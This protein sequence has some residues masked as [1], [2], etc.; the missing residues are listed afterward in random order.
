MV[1]GEGKLFFT[2]QVL[3]YWQREQTLLKDQCKGFVAVLI[4]LTVFPL[5]H[6]YCVEKGNIPVP[7]ATFCSYVYFYGVVTCD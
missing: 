7:L 5:D 3:G 4:S 1:N 2:A 6:Q